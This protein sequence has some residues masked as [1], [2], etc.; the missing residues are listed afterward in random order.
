MYMD[1]QERQRHERWL[2]RTL[3]LA[4]ESIEDG[5]GPFGALV[6]RGEAVLGTG[7]NRVTLWNDPTAH[8]EVVA[9]RE[10]C[11]VAKSFALQGAV[12]YTSCEPCPMCLAAAYWARVA[13]V[14]FAGEPR[15]AARAGFDDERLYRELSLPR[16]RR[17]LPSHGALA[18]EARSVFDAW[19]AKRD[20][21]PY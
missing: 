1:A 5:G 16:E 17:S 4:R 21:V 6:V 12:L 14:W 7:K 13:G 19:L 20:R 18:D 2:R 10:A 8:A 3:E 9:L 15:D 11:Q